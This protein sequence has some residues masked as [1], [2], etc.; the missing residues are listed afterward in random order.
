MFEERKED[1]SGGYMSD[2][3]S[4]A[5][6]KELAEREEEEKKRNERRIAVISPNVQTPPPPEP[7]PEA[8][9]QPEP[10]PEQENDSDSSGSDA[11][12]LAD[13][14][15]YLSRSTLI[16]LA[17]QALDRDNSD[18]DTPPPLEAIIIDD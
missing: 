15:Q 13:Y 7:E 11:I 8:D 17:R 4:G 9:P 3:S 16:V 18:S 1:G 5:Y 10:A 2:G 14:V 6:E 12:P